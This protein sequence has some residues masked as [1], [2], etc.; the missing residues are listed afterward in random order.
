MDMEGSFRVCLHQVV[1]EFLFAINTSEHWLQ[2]AV[3][4][5]R[6]A[7]CGV[8]SAESKNKIKKKIKKGN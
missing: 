4:K 1:N 8:R 3:P 7:E 2:L 5:T 6:S